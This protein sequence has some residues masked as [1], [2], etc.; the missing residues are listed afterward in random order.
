MSPQWSFP[1][2]LGN[3]RKWKFVGRTD[4]FDLYREDAKHF[5]YN[6]MLV[7]QPI[8]REA[9]YYLNRVSFD[10]PHQVD[11]IMMG[12]IMEGGEWKWSSEPNKKA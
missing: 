3:I 2:R 12:I 5:F 9:V 7:G 4:D 1:S 10:L 8:G 6:V 11:A